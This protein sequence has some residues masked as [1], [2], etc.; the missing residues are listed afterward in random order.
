VA[1]DHL[2]QFGDGA[3]VSVLTPEQ[4]TFYATPV[5]PLVPE[6]PP[7]FDATPVSGNQRKFQAKCT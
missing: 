7:V 5:D 3:P 4:M 6:G 2:H 1:W